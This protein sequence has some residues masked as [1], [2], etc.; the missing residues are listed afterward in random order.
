MNQFG[1]RNGDAWSIIW[2]LGGP[3]KLAHFL[4]RACVGALAT[5]GCL[6]DKHIIEDGTCTYCLVSVFLLLL[7]RNPL[8]FNNFLWIVQ[9]HIFW[10]YFC[11]CI[12]SWIALTYS[13]L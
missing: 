11:G 7:F 5:K 9:L 10:N 8:R 12:L 13:H 2:N 4:W 3:L 6:C 1:G